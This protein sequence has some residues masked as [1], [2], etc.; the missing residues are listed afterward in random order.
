MGTTMMMIFISSDRRLPLSTKNRGAALITVLIIVFMVMTIIS[1]MTYANY[2]VIQR[3]T[4]QKIKE[5]SYA[6]L[7]T[8]VNFGRAGLA[9]SG[10]TSQIDTLTDLWAQPL[11]KTT[12]VENMQMSGY[13]IDE[14]GKFNINDL[15]SNGN[16]NPLILGQFT[17]LLS[18]LNIPSSLATSIALYMA[19]PSSEG[20][21]MSQYTTATPASRPAGRPLIDLAE[22]LLVQGM[23]AQWLYKLAPYI[24][25]IP[26]L[27][28]QYTTQSES[29]NVNSNP[30]AAPPPIAPSA[31]MAT[32]ANATGTVLVNINT[33]P[34]EVIAARSGMPLSVAQRIVTIRSVTPF[35]SQQDISSFLSSNG[36]ILQNANGP[37]VNLGVFATQS[38]YFTIHAIATSGNYEFKWIALVY[39]ASRGGQWPLIL[40]QHPE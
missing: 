31:N 10:A 11:P 34:P 6:I 25:A 30:A 37:S 38:S 16:I 35:Q 3:L 13:I 23:N 33:A 5:Q 7:A 36:I 40:W 29:G 26:V 18:Y 8:A 15:V 27:N 12:V 9:T 39:R 28:Q 24:T 14:Q 21:I 17:T 4:N 19:S 22:L 20:S 2:R 32:P 1:N